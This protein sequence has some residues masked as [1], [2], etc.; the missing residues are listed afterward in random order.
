M[1]WISLEDMRFHAFHGVHEPEKT[2][3]TEF[4]VDLHVQT[5]ISL[6][7][8]FDAIEATVDYEKA[9]RI[10]QFQFEAERPQ[11]LLETV[12]RNIVGEMKKQFP[13][14]MG[15]RVRV[16]KLHP[17]LG[18]RVG[19]SAVEEEESYL[20]LCPRC[21]KPLICYGDDTCWCQASGLH[22]A[23][24]EAIKRQYKNCLCA[25]CTKFYEG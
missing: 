9:Y 18:G 5:D 22:P 12:V 14:M 19:A 2:L 21:S 3:G 15:L 4:V 24:K 23:T 6:A 1:A 25:S 16:R 11:R 20:K 17:P 10:C 13:S 7:A 8:K